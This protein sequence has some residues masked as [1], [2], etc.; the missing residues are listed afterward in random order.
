MYYVPL[1]RDFPAID[2]LTKKR[3]LQYS[4]TDDH[5]IKAQG[6]T[7]SQSARKPLPKSQTSTPPI[8]RPRL[9]CR[10]IQEAADPY[11]QRQDTKIVNDPFYS[12]MG[13]SWAAP[14]R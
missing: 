4:V 7:N 6:Y 11:C 2:A 14:R 1:S 8:Y 12:S 13:P 5:P 3:A 10:R 9:H